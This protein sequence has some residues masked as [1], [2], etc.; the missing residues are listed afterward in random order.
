MIYKQRRN[1]G[2]GSEVPWYAPPYV[3]VLSMADSFKAVR[4]FLPRVQGAPESVIERCN[5][6]RVGTNKT[7][8]TP[9]LREHIMGVIKDWGM[10]RDTLRCLALAT[11]DSP[12]KKE[13]MDLENSVKFSEYEVSSAAPCTLRAGM[14]ITMLLV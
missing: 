4:C 14:L 8:L 11:R 12:P 3:S 9:P 10:G 2:R 6:V 7:A 5:Y 1:P 13:E